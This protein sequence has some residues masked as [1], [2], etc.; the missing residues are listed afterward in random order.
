MRQR[1]FNLNKPKFSYT[2]TV[3]YLTLFYSFICEFAVINQHFVLHGSY[4]VDTAT[5][6]A[7]NKYFACKILFCLLFI[8][9]LQFSMPD[10]EDKVYFFFVK[11]I[12]FWTFN[13]Y[14]IKSIN[15]K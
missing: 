10:S 9:C 13:P 6:I 8:F 14:H 3:L 2:G 12:L 5:T 15:C 4:I 1:A 7:G 11:L